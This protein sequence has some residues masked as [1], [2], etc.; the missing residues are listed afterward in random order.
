MVIKNMI[1]KSESALVGMEEIASYSNVSNTTVL[2]WIRNEDFPA[3]KIGKSAIWISDKEEIDKWRRRKVS[4]L[5]VGEEI[6]SADEI[7]NIVESIV[8]EMLKNNVKAKKR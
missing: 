4:I 6:F 2:D 1:K 8:S 3:K 7:K 5:I